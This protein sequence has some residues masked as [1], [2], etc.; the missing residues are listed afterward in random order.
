MTKKKQ[1]F[2]C[3]LA[4]TLTIASP[5][6]FAE[7]DTQAARDI[8]EIVVDEEK[9]RQAIASR[10]LTW[11]TGS[12]SNNDY[13]S[14]G[15][16]ANF[17]GFVALRVS[18]NHSLSRSA[19]AKETLHVLNKRQQNALISLVEDQKAAFQDVQTARFE[20]NRALEGL[21]V[22][23]KVSREEFLI[24]GEQYGAA[25]AELGRIVGQRLGEVGTSLTVDQKTKLSQIRNQY[26]SGNAR[27][28]KIKGIKT[29]L[30]K[31]DKKELINLGARLLSWTT[32]NKSFNDFEVVGKPSQHFGFVSLRI[33]SNHGVKRGA[34]ANEVLDLLS[35]EQK[36]P[37]DEATQYN[38]EAFDEFMTLRKML[39]RTLEVAL[40]GDVISQE[41]VLEIGSKM[42][43]KEADMTWSQAMAML[44]VRDSMN[45]AQRSG[46]M[47]LRSK[48][49]GKTAQVSDD[50]FSRGR[51]LYAQCALCHSEN[52]ASVGPSISNLINQGVAK[53]SNY[54]NYSS[55]IK[56]FSI[57]N[58]IWSEALLDEF[59]RSPKDMMPGTYMGYNGIKIKS[60][61]EALLHYLKEKP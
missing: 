6:S 28:T 33:E 30:S 39:M 3:L 35:H 45:N 49:T 34:V 55:A 48:Y 13:V 26:V 9:L 54:T 44:E 60:D 1:L 4:G 56:S 17:F 59:L 43:R 32:G 14:V 2:A 57:D 21:L 37:I 10:S 61:R 50:P 52:G 46:L 24:L 31:T 15:R 36:K 18:S 19:I 58:P 7:N 51:Q 47:N 8:N 27:K 53:D 25:E 22:G 41:K 16:L 11:L 5:P 23:E 29:D 12:S 20:M 40:V 38:V 42:G